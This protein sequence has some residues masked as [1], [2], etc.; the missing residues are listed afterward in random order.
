MDTLSHRSSAIDLT[1]RN[2]QRPSCFQQPGRC[3]LF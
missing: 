2:K 3:D 1:K